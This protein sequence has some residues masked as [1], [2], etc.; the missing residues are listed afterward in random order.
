MGLGELGENHPS[1]TKAG[2]DCVALVALFAMSALVC[3]RQS[4]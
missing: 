2:F 1:G 4:K 3:L